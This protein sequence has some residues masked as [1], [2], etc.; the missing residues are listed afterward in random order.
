MGRCMRNRLISA[1][2]FLTLLI[3]LWMGLDLG[4]VGVTGFDPLG[5]LFGSRL[6]IVHVAVGLCA[7]WQISRQELRNVIWRP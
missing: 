2:D 7:A 3:L 6:W 5:W 1:L 4:V